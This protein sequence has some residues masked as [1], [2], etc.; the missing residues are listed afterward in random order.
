MG[1]YQTRAQWEKKEKPATTL[2]C[3]VQTQARPQLPPQLPPTGQTPI[4]AFQ[5]TRDSLRNGK[6]V[7]RYIVISHGR[8]RFGLADRPALYPVAD[9]PPSQLWSYLATY[10]STVTLSSTQSL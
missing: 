2:R 7:R 1:D 9:D 3:K 5:L 6:R 10:V 4:A 8:K